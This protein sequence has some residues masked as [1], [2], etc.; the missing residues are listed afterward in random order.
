M[1]VDKDLLIRM[2]LHMSMNGNIDVLILKKNYL[3]MD[4]YWLEHSG[5]QK[6]IRLTWVQL[7]FYMICGFIHYKVTILIIWISACFV[8]HFRRCSTNNLTHI[9]MISSPMEP[10]MYNHWAG[11]QVRTHAVALACQCHK[12]SPGVCRT[13][14]VT[15]R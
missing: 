14:G 15:W 8:V 10:N 4:Q 7:G 6:I 2:I 9:T 12:F 5:T 1:I 13:A 3:K 11:V